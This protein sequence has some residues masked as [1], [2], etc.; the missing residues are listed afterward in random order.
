VINATLRP[1][2]PREI[3]GTHCIGAWIGPRAL[4]EMAAVGNGELLH[5]YLKIRNWLSA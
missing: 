4:S 2:Y 1:L 3:A 5:G